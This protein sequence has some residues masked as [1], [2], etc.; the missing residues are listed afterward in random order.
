[1]KSLTAKNCTLALST[2]YFGRLHQQQGVVNRA[3]ELYGTALRNLMDD[4]K[5]A[6]KATGVTVLMGAMTL[7]IFE[8]IAFPS[9]SGWLHHAGGV[10]RLIEL[11]GPS[12][13]QSLFERGLLEGSRVTIALDCLIKK[14][15]CFLERAEWKRIPWVGSTELRAAAGEL[16]NMLCDMPGLLEDVERLQSP[17]L[18]FTCRELLY[19]DL[20]ENLLNH[21]NSLHR[22]RWEWESNNPNAC[23]EVISDSTPFQTVLYFSSLAPANEIT[24]Y[25]AMLLLLLKL[26]LQILEL[27]FNAS[28][29]NPLHTRDRSKNPLYLPTQAPNPAAIATEICRSVEYHLL[30]HH[31]SAGAFCLLFPLRMAYQTFQSTSRESKWLESVMVRVADL[32]GFEI[33][34][35]YDIFVSIYDRVVAHNAAPRSTYRAIPPNFNIFG[36]RP[37]TKKGFA[38][39]AFQYI[40]LFARCI[41]A[42]FRSGIVDESSD[43][44][45][46]SEFYHPFTYYHVTSPIHKSLEKNRLETPVIYTHPATGRATFYRKRQ[47]G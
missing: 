45:W 35:K 44:G 25:N 4:L 43:F 46:S 42:I 36:R 28:P 3:F 32:S 1:M 10:G 2:A 13:H 21:L 40:E 23:Y 12:R 18:D 30:N 29:S 26:G 6:A 24:F 11:R 39:E 34:W 15:R 8:F 41:E 33:S 37:N 27:D 38:A 14:K 31:S 20:C 19:R 5:D 9:K 16:H 47:Q 22:W 17:E 7:G